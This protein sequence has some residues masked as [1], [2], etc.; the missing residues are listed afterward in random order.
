VVLALLDVGRE[1]GFGQRGEGLVGDRQT[2]VAQDLDL[3][4]V[5][6]GRVNLHGRTSINRFPASSTV[7]MSQGWTGVVASS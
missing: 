7:A 4:R 1:G 2:G 3:D 5:K 6:A